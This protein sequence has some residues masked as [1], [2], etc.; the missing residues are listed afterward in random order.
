MLESVR[1]GSASHKRR[2]KSEHGVD[3]ELAIPAL[4]AQVLDKND[5]EIVEH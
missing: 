5:H 3:C 2:I 4:L 1:Q